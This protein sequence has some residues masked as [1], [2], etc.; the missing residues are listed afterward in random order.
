MQKLVGRYRVLVPLLFCAM[1]FVVSKSAGGAAERPVVV[2]TEASIAERDDA[3]SLPILAAGD[4]VPD[5]ASSVL[6][7]LF[8]TLKP[9]AKQAIGKAAPSPIVTAALP[10]RSIV[11]AEVSPNFGRWQE[12]ANNRLKQENSLLTRT[13]HPQAVAHPDSYVTVCEAGCRGTPDQIVYTV[14]KTEAASAGPA[15]YV[16]TDSSSEDST[17][18]AVV[19]AAPVT[20]DTDITC[21]AGCYDSPKKIK[22][23]Q[24]AQ[25]AIK[26]ASAAAVP[27]R[28]I[29]LRAFD[30][31]R[32]VTVSS[33]ARVRNKPAPPR[34]AVQI[35]Y[36]GAIVSGEPQSQKDR[37]AGVRGAIVRA[38]AL[39]IE[40]ESAGWRTRVIKAS[41]RNVVR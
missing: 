5:E 8:S 17:K 4:V 32:A 3:M 11:L 30:R 39:R 10:E 21:V 37:R 29:A 7:R 2:L 16:P 35:G 15:P 13:E 28:A 23:R 14:V 9:I 38:I 12:R 34:R 22:A 19:A 40:G 26:K 18:G 27:G 25:T 1:T 6:R 36:N 20:S 41:A 24:S 33:V 31:A